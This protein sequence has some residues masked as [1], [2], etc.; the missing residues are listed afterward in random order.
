MTDD[1]RTIRHDYFRTTS[2]VTTLFCY[3]Y[4]YFIFVSLRVRASFIFHP[5]TPPRVV[6]TMRASPARVGLAPRARPR[7]TVRPRRG[8]RAAP[9]RALI[10]TE[11]EAF[12]AFMKSAS[13]RS[14]VALGRGENGRGLF[15]TAPAGW[16]AVELLLEVPLDVCIVCPVGRGLA[17]GTDATAKKIV[18]AWEKRNR[19]VPDA[20]KDLMF[21]KDED[22]RELAV[23][24]WLLFATRAGGDI[25][26]A[27]AAWLPTAANGLPSTL[28]ATDE[29]L[30]S[31]Q[32]EALVRRAREVRSLVSLAFDRVPFGAVPGKLTPDDLRWG[33][34]LVTS[35]AI[36]AEVGA[37]EEGGAD[38]TQV[39]VLAPC[40]DMANHVDIANVT[41]LKKIGASDGGGLKG[42]YWRVVTGGS[43]DGGGGAC[44]LETNRPIQGADEEVTISYQPDASNDELM[45]SYGFS[46]RGNRNDRLG[47]ANITLRLGA[48]RQAMEESGVLGGSTPEEDVRR[49]IAV[50][51]S[52]CGGI[53]PGRELV[54]DDDWTL[55]GDDIQRELD[56]AVKLGEAW[57]R[58]LDA[59]ATT[60]EEDEAELLENRKYT[61][62][63]GRAA[64]EYRAERKRLLGVG[65]GAL[66]AYVDWLCADDDEEG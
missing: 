24:L 9:T 41:A 35:R 44:C 61:T 59:F 4:D 29:E 6:R 8:G 66:S 51:A 14:R 21:S 37:D 62:A 53:P 43:V 42:A 64:V 27:Y 7:R 47:G 50:T 25:W 33:Y 65:L 60:L 30:A 3:G 32:N 18:G 46:L 12:D 55:E 58:E 16:K 31:T 19:P 40:V 13:M 28:L 5:H 63:F 1:A 45:E 15:T 36:A 22:D 56:D 54:A 48:F 10:T 23:V 34:A 57:E 20:I 26:E 49:I 17:T 38:D 52:A 11:T 2:R 39:A